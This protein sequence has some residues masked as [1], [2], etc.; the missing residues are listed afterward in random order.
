MTCA[1]SLSR[2]GNDVVAPNFWHMPND[3]L[4][5]VELTDAAYVQ[6]MRPTH[7]SVLVEATDER[8]DQPCVAELAAHTYPSLRRQLTSISTLKRSLTKKTETLSV[9]LSSN[10]HAKVVGGTYE[11]RG[12]SLE[13]SQK[14][15]CAAAP[16]TVRQ[17]HT[18]FVSLRVT[19][20]THRDRLTWQRAGAF[21][22]HVR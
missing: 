11:Q 1:Y 16:C 8:L 3:S 19:K 5:Y 21:G 4:W 20:T 18:S 22:R 13:R 15:S 12:G 17:D 10:R 7:L 6:T 14:S 2:G 9:L